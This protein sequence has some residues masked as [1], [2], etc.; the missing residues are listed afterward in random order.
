MATEA[1][2]NTATRLT[3]F[4]TNTYPTADVSPGSVLNELL[5]KLAS[6]LE[7]Q[8]YNL[9]ETLSTG[10]SIAN[11]QAST[12]GTYNPVIDQI[13]SNYLATRISGTYSTGVIKVI[14]S[15]TKTGINL[16]SGISFTQPALGLIY[17]TTA[18]YF[19]STTPSTSQEQIFTSSSDN[20]LYVLV[21][22]TAMSTG[23]AYQVQN[24]AVFTL[25]SGSNFPGFVSASAYGNFTSGQNEETDQALIKRFKTAIT[26]ANLT[27]PVG[28]TNYLQQH[29]TS[30]AIV[31]AVG[32]D[33]AEM[34]RSKDNILGISTFGMADIYIRTSFGREFMSFTTKAVKLSTGVWQI[35]ISNTQAPGFYQVQSVL[36]TP[37]NGVQTVTGSLTILSTTFGYS[38]FPGQV[39]NVINTAEE[40]RFTTYQ[41]AAVN[42]TY[43][44][45]PTV[46]AGNTASFDVIVSGQPF[47]QEAQQ[48]FLNDNMRVINAD[49]LVKAVVPCF[50]SLQIGLDK[51]NSTDTPASVGIPALQQAIFNYVNTIPFGGSVSASKIVSLCH[52]YPISSVDLPI[53]MTGQVLANDGTTI[54][55][56]NT[57]LLSIPTNIPLG[58]TPRTSQ[59]FIDYFVPGSTTN[60]VNNIGITLN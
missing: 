7:N 41:T 37:V 44:E 1:I 30:N 4:I 3:T 32:A 54:N 25:S 35:L 55:I 38:F 15:N 49:Y 34:Q 29:I 31:S 53:T 2:A 60:V 50:V 6:S 27:S 40:A 8:Q 51:L 56:S 47:I 42:F 17:Q 14:I 16:M 45:V 11:A 9:I 58:I 23:S 18:N 12:S 46:A 43:N 24:Q 19:Y 10:N 36:P 22:V 33:D 21:P 26:P 28:I 39:N 13:A 20:T 52:Q 48:L 59:F 5:I 57:D